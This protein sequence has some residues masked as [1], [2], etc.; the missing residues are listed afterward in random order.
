MLRNT[1]NE[2]KVHEVVFNDQTLESRSA[3]LAWRANNIV[4]VRNIIA[5]DKDLEDQ[6]LS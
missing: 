4:C 6:E 2:Y 1:Q 3:C 5:L